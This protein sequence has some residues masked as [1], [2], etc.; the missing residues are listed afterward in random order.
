MKMRK[1]MTNKEFTGRQVKRYLVGGATLIPEPHKNG[2]WVTY[3]DAKR[4]HDVLKEIPIGR[5]PSVLRLKVRD[6]LAEWETGYDE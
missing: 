3:E 5:I 6:I 4:L 1:V 2:V